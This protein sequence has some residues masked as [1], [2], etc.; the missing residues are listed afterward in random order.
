MYFN[1]IVKRKTTAGRIFTIPIIFSRRS[2]KGYFILS[3]LLSDLCSTLKDTSSQRGFPDT[4]RL[5]VDR[6]L[7]F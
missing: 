4:P 3:L 6:G 7:Y 2:K 5:D 1:F